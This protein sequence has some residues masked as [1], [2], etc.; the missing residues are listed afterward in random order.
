[1]FFVVPSFSLLFRFP[2][3]PSFGLL[4]YLKKF[5]WYSILSILCVFFSCI[6]LCSFFSDCSRDYSKQTTVYL[7]SPFYHFKY[8]VDA[9]APFLFPLYAGLVLCH[10]L[11]TLEAHQTVLRF[12]L[13]I[14]RHILNLRRLACYI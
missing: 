12:L 7:E 13:S 10:H 3:L 2:L 8:N 9:R 4:E 6:S 1:M 14:V 11:H 5:F